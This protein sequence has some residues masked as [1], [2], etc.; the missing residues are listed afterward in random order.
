MA[1]NIRPQFASRPKRAVL[2]RGE[3]AI[4]EAICLAAGY[5]GLPETRIVTNLVAPSPSR[6]TSLARFPAKSV[7]I[8]RKVV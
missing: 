1:H 5:E 8:L 2:T 6:T 3:R 4:V 7:S